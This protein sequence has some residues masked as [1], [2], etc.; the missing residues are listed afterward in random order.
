[1]SVR[2]WPARRGPLQQCVESSIG[3]DTHYI[4]FATRAR[5]GTLRGAHLAGTAP[6]RDPAAGEER[7][8]RGAESLA[9]PPVRG[10]TSLAPAG[11]GARARASRARA[12]TVVAETPAG[13]RGAARGQGSDGDQPS[14]DGPFWW[15]RE[16]GLRRLP[17]A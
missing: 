13:G 8:R 15:N 1:M 14:F 10:G 6:G 5:A 2:G 16:S 11:R 4:K 9:A 3:L 12:F 7:A 17:S